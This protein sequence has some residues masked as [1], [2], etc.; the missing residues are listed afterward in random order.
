MTER[1]GIHRSSYSRGAEAERRAAQPRSPFSHAGV[2]ALQALAGNHAVSRMLAPGPAV[3]QRVEVKVAGGTFKDDLGDGY[4]AY[5][6]KD[7]R[8][9]EHGAQMSQLEF[10]PD[11]NLTNKSNQKATEV[12]LVQTTNSSVRQ[13]G[14]TKEVKDQPESLLDKRR[15]ESG[16]AIDQQI[17]LPGGK[18]EQFPLPKDTL[19]GLLQGMQGKGTAAGVDPILAD[20]LTKVDSAD[21]AQINSVRAGILTNKLE[22]ILKAERQQG[23][24]SGEIESGVDEAKE[25]IKNTRRRMNLDPRYAEERSGATGAMKPS[26]VAGTGAKG[27]TG[28]N[29]KRGADDA[30]WAGAAVLR[31]RPAHKVSAGTELEGQEEFE[32]AAM[33]DGEKLVG[34][35]NWGWK[36]NGTTSELLH[37]TIVKADE[38]ESSKEFLRAAAAWN[39]MDVRNPVKPEEVHTPM[40][41]PTSAA[42]MG[43]ARLRKALERLHTGI[44][45]G[46]DQ[47]LLGSIIQEASRAWTVMAEDGRKECRAKVLS[48]LDEFCM[49]IQHR[50]PS[51]QALAES[52]GFPGLA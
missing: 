41:L 3:V 1:V 27:T 52:F 9:W 5:N 14:Q 36:I 30:G 50:R 2:I 20:M 23:H 39:V 32:V 28:W 4:V 51:Q 47:P 7:D 49:K 12:S 22:M 29:A 25:L 33:A 42:A 6:V 13:K 16:A 38:G 18:T 37:P 31:D 40:Q 48:V 11:V 24:P 17:F 44:A 45:A 34:S 19:K 26:E 21:Y 8:L 43:E 35:I 15:T 46:S 10:R